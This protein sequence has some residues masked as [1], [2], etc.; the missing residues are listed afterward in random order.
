MARSGLL[1]QRILLLAAAGLAFAWLAASL[2]ASRDIDSA[3]RLASFGLLR[4]VSDGE[5]EQAQ[6]DL[7]EARRFNTDGRPLYMEV[8]LLTLAGR[9][10]QALHAAERLVRMEPARFEGWRSIY[11]LTRESDPAR[12]N[13][14]RRRALELNPRAATYM[15]RVRR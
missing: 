14:A 15:P 3:G 9:P 8:G 11:T 6:S 13:E 4:S 2:V 1:G 7:D 10:R 12:A 5:I